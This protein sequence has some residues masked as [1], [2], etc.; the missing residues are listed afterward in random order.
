MP[1]WLSN[2]PPALYLMLAA[3]ALFCGYCAW[4]SWQQSRYRP[5]GPAAETP[6]LRAARVWGLLA[7]LALLALPLLF[8]IDRMYESDAEQIARKL[9]EM[10]AGVVRRDL[11]SVFRHISD[12]F[13][14]NEFGSKQ[15][16][17]DAAGRAQQRGYVDEVRIWD[18]HVENVAS[19]ANRAV[20][21]FKFKVIGSWGTGSEYFSCRSE[22]VRES[23]NEWRLQTFQVF[24]PFVDANTPMAIP[25]P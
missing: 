18:I 24:N 2:P 11:D 23:G 8:V 19:G 5:R 10:S 21:E 6:R 7:A 15:A 9:N 20:A 25:V 22:W 3:A 12:S 14:V 4:A 16:M 17:R 1:N 13:K